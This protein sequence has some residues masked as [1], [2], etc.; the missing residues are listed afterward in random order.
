MTYIVKPG[1]T[2]SKIAMRYGM[3][4]PQLLQANPQINDPNK[5]KVGDAINTPDGA[6]GVPAG[7]T[8]DTK[9][10]PANPSAAASSASSTTSTSEATS[11]AAGA[12]GKALAFE[13]GI[14][15][16][17]YETGGRGPGTV[18][19]GVGDPGGV[20]YGSYQMATKTGT[21]KRFVTQPDFPWLQAF[22]NLTPG[23]A[24][25]SSCWKR[26]ATNETDAFQKCQHEYIKKTHYDLLVAKILGDD[27]VDINTRSS[28][29]Q[30]VVWSTAVQHGPGTPIVHRA[31]ANVSSKPSD[32]QYDEQ[33]IRAIYAERGR[34]KPDGNLAYFGK[35][36]PSVQ[37]GVANRFKNEL[38]DALSMLAKEL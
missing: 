18:S 23:T 31:C 13:L 28:T 16:A 21:A 25:F 8:D 2:L 14:L 1:D 17:K 7:S 3:S 15:S 37:A 22:Q 36:S 30:N 24:D 32:S 19:S 9:P 20:S 12:L 5:I 34:K 26:I 6:S 38:Q 29:L 11:D 35:S 27:E 33:L 4:L 10:L